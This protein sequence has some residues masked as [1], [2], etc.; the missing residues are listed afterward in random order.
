LRAISVS[1]GAVLLCV[2]AAA[3]VGL[4]TLIMISRPVHHR[5]SAAMLFAVYLVAGIAMVS[6]AA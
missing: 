4:A 3:G 6:L 5:R 2:I 1:D